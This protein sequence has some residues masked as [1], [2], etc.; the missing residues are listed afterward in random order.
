MKKQILLVTLVFLLSLTFVS[1][2]IETIPV[3]VTYS[4]ESNQLSISGENLF[5]QKILT[6]ETFSVSLNI[7]RASEVSITDLQSSLSNM[8]SMCNSSMNYLNP[9]I[10]CIGNASRLQGVE[11]AYNNTN[12]LLSQCTTERD[13][14]NNQVSI[15]P[16]LTKEKSD[17]TS[18]RWLFGV[19]GVI[20]GAVGYWFLKV[21]KK[22][23]KDYEDENEFAPSGRG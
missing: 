2:S 15:I 16:T 18:Q 17:A 5:W 14:L 13:N 3:N 9:L 12:A 6:N 21:R 1:A 19:G 10:E 11:L 23:A 20:V 4:N 22:E 8:T 7:I